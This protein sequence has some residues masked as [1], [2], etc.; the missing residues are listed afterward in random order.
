MDITPGHTGTF[1]TI[2]AAVNA[3]FPGDTILADP[4]TYAESVTINKSLV[5][6]G[7]QHG[8]DAR[9]RSGLESIV[10]GVGNNGRTPFFVTASNVTIDGFTIEGATNSNQ[11]GFGI[12]VGAGTSGT[13]VLNN[14]IQDN[15]AGLS[16]ANNSTSNQTVIQ[17]NLFRNNNQPGPVSGTGI[18]SDQFN[19]GG[20]L[21]DVLIDANTFTG[22]SDAGI[23]FSSTDATRPATGITVSNNVFDGNGRGLLAFN[24]TSSTISS[25]TFSN[26]TQSASADIRLFEGNNGLT[27]TGNLLENGAGRALRISNIG[28][29]SPDSSNIRFVLNS[30][31][32]YTGPAGT[33]QVDN[34]T[35]TL[36]A[37]CNWWG[38]ISGP[39]VASNPGGLG[40]TLVD[41]GNHVT[42]RP[43]LVYGTDA[44][45]AAPGFQLPT[46]I[47]VT[48]GGDVSAADNDYTRLANAIACAQ[49]GQTIILSGTFDWTLPFASAA[50]AKGVDGVAG[51]GDD[52]HIVVPANINNVTVT[53]NSLGSATIQG[54]GDLPN[55][56]FEGVLAFIDPTGTK[57]GGGGP[58]TGWT[59]SNLQVFDFDNAIEYDTITQGRFNGTTITHNHIRV[60]RDLN[61]IVAPNDPSQNIGIYFGFGTNQTISD[62]VIDIPGDGVRDSGAGGFSG[63]YGIQCAT[64]GGDVYDGLRITG[65][66]I[67]VLN[68]Q[69]S[70]P[71]RVVGIWE[72]SDGTASN[73]LVANNTFRD[74]AA[75]N[76]PALNDQIAFRLTS[77]SSATTTIMYQNN[78]V[79]GA[80]VGFQYYP[81]YDNTGTQPVRLLDNTLTDVFNGFDFDNGAKTV[82]Y[83]SGNSVTGSGGSGV[84]VGVG[85]GS[86]LTTDG[87][88]GT[89]TISGFATGVNVDGGTATLTQNTI[90]ANAVGVAVANGGTLVSAQQNF[91]KGNAEGITVAASAGTVG[92]VFNNDLSGN[93]VGIDNLTAAVIDAGGNWWG[94]PTGPAVASNPGGAGTPVSAL[95]DYSPWLTSG[96]DTSLAPGFQ[97]DFSQLAV[98]PG[99]PRNAAQVS[100][101]T[102]N[103]QEGV[104]DVLPNGTVI[105]EAGTYAENV[106][107]G[108]NLTLAGFP[109]NPPAA[110]IHPASGDGV[111]VSAPATNVTLENLEV[112]GAATGV[113]VA[114]VVTV[115][116][117]N[118][119]LD[120][121]STGFTA[122]NLTTLNLADL[123]LSG[124]T[125]AGGT[126]TNVPTVNDTPT[127][128]GTG[129]TDTITPT[130]FRR[131][132]DQA[133]TYSGVASLNVFGGGG[134]DTFDVTPSSTTA[135]AINGGPPDPP[136]LPGDTLNV[137]LAGTNNPVLTAAATPT[138]YQG[139]WTFGNRQ[140]VTFQRIESVGN[141][142]DLALT[143]S[144]PATSPEGSNLT[145]TIVVQNNGPADAT[146]VTVTD[147]LPG[148]VQFVSANFPQGS[149][150]VVSGGTVTINLGTIA[151]HASVTGTVVVRPSQ[152][153]GATLTNTAS[154]SSDVVDLATG[155]NT[156]EATVTLSEGDALT[157]TPGT[158]TATEGQA[159]SGPVATF[160]DT[161][162]SSPASDFSAMI[163][164]GDG[165]T[166]GGTV[167]GSAGSFTVSG[168]HTYADEGPFHPTVSVRENSPGTASAS[169]TGT[170]LVAEGDTLTGSGVNV[171]ATEGQAFSGPVA[172]FTDTTYPGNPGSDFG[173]TIDWGD[174]TTTAG[175]V[176]AAGGGTF[177][178]SGSHTY[179]DEGPFSVK[180]VLTDNAPSTASATAMASA[181]VAEA[182]SLT[183]G[184]T[185]FSATE[186][187]AFSG[188]VATFTDTNPSAPAG[189][190]T[191]TIDWGDGTTD[192]GTVSGAA[193]GPFT[194]AGSHTY[195]EQGTHSVRVVLTDDAPGT[196]SATANSTAVIAEA[197]LSITGAPV[198]ATEGTAFS[199]K[200]ATLTDANTFSTAADFTATIDWG[201]GTTTAGTVTGSAGHFT[202]GGQHTYADE[203]AFTATVTVRETSAPPASAVSALDAVTVAEGD[204]LAAVTS[205]ALT[206]A[207][208]AAF[209]GQVAVF[210]DTDTASVA[211]G[212][213]ATITWGDGTTTAGTVTG[214]SGTFM[215][216]GSHT[217][218]ESGSFPVTV[219][220]A[221]DAP[222][223]AAL[224]ASGT[225]AVAAVPIVSLAPIPVNQF[226]GVAS[227]NTPLATFSHAGG[228]ESPGAFTVFIAWGDGSSSFGTVVKSGQTYMVL[229]SHTYAGEATVPGHQYPVDIS[230]GEGGTGSVHVRTSATV[231]EAPLPAGNPDG[232]RGTANE[233]WLSEA[234]SDLHGGRIDLATLN[235]LNGL[236]NRGKSRLHV[237]GVLLQK[238]SERSLLRSLAVG[239]KHPSSRLLAA[240]A[241]QHYLGQ[242]PDASLFKGV[243]KAIAAGGLKAGVARVLSSDEYYGLTVA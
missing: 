199:D 4:G 173:A 225:A 207:E 156:Q 16:L 178:V 44:D 25:N 49:S 130:S 239:R 30:I 217:Y 107:V 189:D 162:T 76:N 83:L 153:E 182:D 1:T 166:T 37:S 126:V 24:L 65:N 165:T 190:F 236:L 55:V 60:A 132:A 13:H 42:Y 120:G 125:V 51:N 202:V 133:V 121:N 122:L 145:F 197:P 101:G 144:A 238:V 188:T 115:T 146:N 174:G 89:N 223:T 240:A 142:A 200:V 195:A 193:G 183:A 64:S 61:D 136:A 186:G 198:A 209:N 235:H 85:P 70:D 82:N 224:T 87:T 185:T 114:G 243:T 154:V 93:A 212:F 98:N 80:H 8:V 241:F 66:T 208:G 92:R 179:A 12:L 69:S 138:G 218:A 181:A 84:G 102:A 135:F 220:L 11:F 124:N 74:L 5:L 10:T 36:D 214:G 40:Q 14:I 147:T 134:S 206:P 175:T 159:F 227:I 129:A 6:E 95:V 17:H 39:T 20:T 127:S 77:P 43:W 22:N 161:N 72:N 215:V 160:S 155:N 119:K 113:N 73:I 221:D 33:V 31:S 139:S 128:G 91:I 131:D 47:T 41:P 232:P 205:P 118:L 141:T 213:T 229:G 143:Q 67:N 164:W 86:T 230:V 19:A 68:A 2:Q 26:S 32:G 172:T 201:D 152:D 90:D 48:A 110:V 106:T 222:G 99:S 137:A 3:A 58:N 216:S 219:T 150:P 231:F 94:D 184:A 35:G 180:V 187:S 38:A 151:A 158:V 111:T 192:A 237:A 104:N 105:A 7:A 108:K 171:N 242:V 21:S 167:A 170:A 103:L 204:T 28:T 18:Y 75:G 63:T 97:G 88:F 52:Y 177:T 15:I 9:T 81:T 46:S 196:A 53:A 226:E 117:Q 59:I 191:A 45:P 149:A 168:S 163:D 100:A 203:G 54:P 211:A 29:G 157:V 210:S 34:Y 62:N 109:G 50:W 148:G 234:F 56:D 78:T 233:R 57:P 23:D 79:S 116:L 71:E 169:A 194:V 27:I 112:T 140:P 96:A 228:T 123:A 176:A